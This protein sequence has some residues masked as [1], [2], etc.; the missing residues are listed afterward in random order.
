LT[1]RKIK[2]N[3]PVSYLVGFGAILALLGLQRKE[4]VELPRIRLEVTFI[5]VW[6]PDT[7]QIQRVETKAYPSPQLNKEVDHS[8]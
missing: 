5:Q 2:S 8:V 1:P 6:K 7:L 3:Q 4:A